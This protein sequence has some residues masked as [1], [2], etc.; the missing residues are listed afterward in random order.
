M[1]NHFH[2]LVQ[3]KDEKGKG[4]SKFM[5]KLMTSYTMYFNTKYERTG[6]LFSSSFKA[7][8]VTRDEH[9]KY[10]FAYIHLN[11]RS[12]IGAAGM[13]SYPYS[14]L[15]EY[16]GMQ[17]PEGAILNRTAFPDY[18]SGA[19]DRELNDWLEEGALDFLTEV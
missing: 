16:R 19:I 3:E 6:A 17:R 11:P 7:R 2:L 4:V 8:H 15:H 10:L 13:R 5:Q 14:S 1:P 18:F 12:V 9:L